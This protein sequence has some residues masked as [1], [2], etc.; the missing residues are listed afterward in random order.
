[1]FIITCLLRG[2][3]GKM[4]MWNRILNVFGFALVWFLVLFP[5]PSAVAQ[6]ASVW[7]T[8]VGTDNRG[9]EYANVSIKKDELS[10]SLSCD[11]RDTEN[12]QLSFLLHT[13]SVPMLFAEDDLEETLTLRFVMLDKSVFDQPVMAH[14]FDGGPDDQAWVG[15][16]SG[17]QPVINAMMNAEGVLLLNPEQHVVFELS[18]DG[19]ADGGEAIHQECQVG[20]LNELHK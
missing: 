6:D 4:L 7:V 3:L 13:P 5:L 11:T 18:N 19:L 8:K 1:M 20:S 14:Y 2:R 16:I 12:V 15:N 10:L 9:L 17:V